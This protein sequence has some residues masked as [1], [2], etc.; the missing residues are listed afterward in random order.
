MGCTF[1]NG[2]DPNR[3]KA[4][5]GLHRSGETVREDG[6]GV[7][8]IITIYYGS[9]RSVGRLVSAALFGR[10][11]EFADHVPGGLALA[12]PVLVSRP[13]DAK[14]ISRLGL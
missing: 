2:A 8:A 5:G 6:G 7:H 13:M 12:V 3:H 14:R 11:R 4:F 1:G 9:G 10:R